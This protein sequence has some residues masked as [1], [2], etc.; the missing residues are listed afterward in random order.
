[1]GRRRAVDRTAGDYTTNGSGSYAEQTAAQHFS[2]DHGAGN[3]AD[4]LAGRRRG[5]TTVFLR[6]VGAAV[7]GV[8]MWVCRRVG[9][10]R[11]R[12]RA[13]GRYQRSRT[14]NLEQVPHVLVFLSFPFRDSNELF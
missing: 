7:I 5:M 10:R 11:R 13:A 9:A 2:A 14:Y 12:D 1:V 8:M 6:V 3:A 4:N